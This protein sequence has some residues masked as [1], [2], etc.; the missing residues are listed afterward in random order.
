MVV[1]YAYDKFIEVGLTVPNVNEGST[2]N[3]QLR[4]QSKG[5][6]N[7][8]SVK[9]D[10]T[11]FDSNNISVGKVSTKD[12][13]LPALSNLILFAPFNTSGLSSGKYRAEAAVFYDEKKT[14]AEAEFNIG[15]LD[16][17]VVNYTTV[18]EQGFSEFS[19]MVKNNWGNQLRDIYARLFIE[20]AELLQTPTISL[21]P[22]Q[23]GKL[24]GLI[25]IDLAP[26]VYAGKVKLFYEDEEKE[27]PVTVKIVKSASENIPKENSS[28]K[29]N[30]L[31]ILLIGS[32]VLLSL[33][34]VYFI[35]RRNRGDK[36]GF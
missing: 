26:G 1:V 5:Y 22:W 31:V 19:L 9:A 23:E 36:D 11:F 30:I 24:S 33:I 2:A 13:P 32:T 34:L 15:A 29:N 16:L 21:E 4:V 10:I 27:L 17:Q 12:K 25:K 18:L 3:I 14:T 7:I 8:N 28:E 20:E 6:I 35:Y